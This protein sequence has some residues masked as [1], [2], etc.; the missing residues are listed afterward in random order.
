MP[1]G[2]EEKYALVDSGAGVNVCKWKKHF[3]GAKLRKTSHVV[4]MTTATS[5]E[6][7]S[8]GEVVV[9]AKTQE[10]HNVTTVFQ[11]ADVDLPILSVAVLSDSS[12]LGSDVR[13]KRN[14]GYIEDIAT[15]KRCNF[16]K[17]QG[18]YFI[19]L[20]VPK[21]LLEENEQDFGRQA[22]P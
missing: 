20:L 1:E 10:G 19:K 4:K 13:F 16:I 9:A 2:Y 7:V 12:K 11:D 3:P 6:I 5:E 14:D 8:G 17:R 15:G 22:Q 18:V 21:D